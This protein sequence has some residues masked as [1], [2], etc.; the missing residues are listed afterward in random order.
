MNS[1]RLR[2]FVSSLPHVEETLQWGDNLVFWVGD[3]VIG[4]KMF[5]LVDLED[6]QKCVVSFAAGPEGAAELC[7]REGIIPAPY[8]ARVHWVGVERWDALSSSAWKECL[9]RAHALTLAKLSK[10][11]LEVLAMSERQRSAEVR[12][13]RKRLAE[14]RSA[15]KRSVKSGRYR[16][17]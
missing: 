4:G 7:E 17:G 11:T 16:S 8:F 12:S 10:R 14:K 15:E 2:E 1:E 3:K 13:A 6:G 5:C 9:T